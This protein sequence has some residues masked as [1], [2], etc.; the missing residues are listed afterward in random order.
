MTPNFLWVLKGVAATF[1]DSLLY[2]IASLI[3]L[4]KYVA[5]KSICQMEGSV[6]TKNRKIVDNFIQDIISTTFSCNCP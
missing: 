5:D 6:K 1:E 4:P 3:I 2:S